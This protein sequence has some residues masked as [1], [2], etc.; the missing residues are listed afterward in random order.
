MKANHKPLSEE[1]V[2]KCFAERETDDDPISLVIGIHWLR[3]LGIYPGLNKEFP[4]D[5]LKG[6]TPDIEE[7]QSPREEKFRITGVFFSGVYETDRSKCYARL[8]DVKE[9][10]NAKSGV[11]GIAVNIKSHERVNKLR[12]IVRS[13]PSVREF[14]DYRV[15]TSPEYEKWFWICI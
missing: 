6:M 11:S 15:L 5:V 10:V 12:D 3:D 9:F 1:E 4:D 14:P 2:L 8:E 13:M 7:L